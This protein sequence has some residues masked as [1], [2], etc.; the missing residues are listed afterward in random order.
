MSEETN[1]II[2]E[3]N[4]PSTKNPGR[5]AWGKKLAKMSKDLKE[6]FRKLVKQ[7]KINYLKKILKLINQQ[8][9]N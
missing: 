7:K 1:N 9:I 5:V 2:V 8:K 3:A 4:K 6:K